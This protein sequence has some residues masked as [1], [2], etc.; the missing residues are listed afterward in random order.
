MR[1]IQSIN[2]I[3]A[4]HPATVGNTRVLTGKPEEMRPLGRNGRRWKDNIRKELIGI[5]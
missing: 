4:G 5:R 2:V 1:M 3:I